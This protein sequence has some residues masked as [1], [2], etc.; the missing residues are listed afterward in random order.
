MTESLKH[1][2]NMHGIDDLKSPSEAEEDDDLMNLGQKKT[3]RVVQHLADE[4]YTV[5]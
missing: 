3:L 4:M 1:V 2:L 5:N